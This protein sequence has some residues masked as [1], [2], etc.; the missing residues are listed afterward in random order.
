MTGRPL[1]LAV[2]TSHP[3]QY[4]AP[5]FRELAR[6]VDLTVFYGHR[7]TAE[8]QARA[9]FGVGFEWDVD[10]TTGFHSIFLDNRA[11]HPGLARFS[12][13]D[14]P[15]IGQRLS[16]GRFDAVLLI[17]W[18]KKFLVQ[19]LVAARR[20]GIPALMRGDS[21]LGT[22]RSLL[23]RLAKELVYPLFLRQY[24]G[25]LAVG[26]R[27]RSYWR[28]YHYPAARIFASPHCIDAAWFAE[29]GTVAAGTALRRRLGI[30]ADAPLVLFAGKLIAFK[31]PLEVVEAAARLRAAG[32]PVQILVAGDGPLRAAMAAR[33]GNLAVPLHLLGFCNQ[34]EMPAAYAAA[35]VLALPSSRSETWGLVVN[36]ALACGTP[37]V[38]SDAV[39]CAPDLV[40]LLGNRSC[41]PFGDVERLA[42]RLG[43]TLD[44]PPST[45]AMAAANQAL[46]LSAAADG[47]I[48][49]MRTVVREKPLVDVTGAI[50]S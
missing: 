34:S 31:R 23:V 36:E 13:I 42:A 47:V 43:E 46:S 44:S 9:G 12:G 33:A 1:H 4:Y 49:A 25:A 20:L 35:D 29:R 17:G 37:A 27:N 39:G 2:V 32:T 6:R 28:H 7:A 16:E 18:H 11:R 40:R 8:D 50:P 41:F 19:A 3:V 15:Q 22:A 24:A 48:A 5:L 21:Q 26:A 10:L 38:V 30:A 45:A 14:T